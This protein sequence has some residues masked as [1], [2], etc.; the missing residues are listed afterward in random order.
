MEREV[1]ARMDRVTFTAI[2]R[3][4]YDKK[5]ISSYVSMS[6]ERERLFK[7]IEAFCRGVQCRKRD[8]TYRVTLTHTR[9]IADPVFR[10]RFTTPSQASVFKQTV[11]KTEFSEYFTFVTSTLSTWIG[12]SVLWLDPLN[13][14]SLWQRRQ[15][16]RG[17]RMPSGLRSA[18]QSLAH[19]D[20]LLINALSIMNRR[21]C[22]LE[23]DFLRLLRSLRKHVH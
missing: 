21:V 10:M 2:I 14:L 7:Q 4:R 18:R 19:G 5:L 8:C 3:K 22:R 13:L 23:Q 20:L 15:R 12:I 16:R 11:A 1:L 6:R 9:A 17:Q